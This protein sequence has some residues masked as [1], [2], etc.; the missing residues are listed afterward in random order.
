MKSFHLLSACSTLGLTALLGCSS[1]SE[2]SHASPATV[3]GMNVTGDSS[4]ATTGGVAQATTSPADADAT[5][6]GASAT[7][8]ADTT[9]TAGQTAT[10]GSGGGPATSAVTSAGDSTSTGTTGVTSAGGAT[11]GDATSSGGATTTGEG[12]TG[13]VSDK[14]I[15]NIAPKNQDVP[16]DFAAK[17]EQMSMEANSKWGFVQPN[18]PDDWVW[19]PVDEAYQYAKENGVIFKQHNFFWNFEQPSWV[20]EGNVATYAPI[21]IQEFCERYPDVAQIDVVN[22]PFFNSAPY[23]GGMGGA[24]E[25]GYDWVIQAFEWADEYCP[26]AILIINEFNIVEWE[27]DHNFFV[28]ALRKIMDAGAP[29]DAIGAQGHDIYRA[30]TDVALGYIDAL[31]A[32]FGLPIYITELDIDL[33]NDEEQLAKMQEIIP[34]LWNHPNVHGITYW[35]FLQGSTWRTNAWLVSTS[36]TERPAMT[37]LQQFIADHR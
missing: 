20:N 5:T 9:T 15:G 30:G 34:A 4:A 23:R 3:G 11:S 1:A 29:I 6:A 8:G 33:A 26:N 7:T 28:E 35:G 27:D 14:F 36:G 25:S 10:S 37:W 21:W 32:E 13:P 17:W 31:T 19:E 24:G 22:E 12:T 2:D 18:G 16:A